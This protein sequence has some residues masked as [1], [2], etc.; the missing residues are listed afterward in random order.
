MRRS[1]AERGLRSRL[2]GKE[3]QMRTQNTGIDTTALDTLYRVYGRAVQELQEH[4][5]E[6]TWEGSDDDMRVLTREHPATS[7]LSRRQRRASA[8]AR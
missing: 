6:S 2:H 5:E 3:E 8:V 1:T 4:A 7:H